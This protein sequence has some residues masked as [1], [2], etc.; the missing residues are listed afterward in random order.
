VLEQALFKMCEQCRDEGHGD[1]W[2]VF[3]RRVIQPFWHG[4]PEPTCEELV[5]ELG[6]DSPR[7]ASNALITAKRHFRRVLEE[8]V[9]QYLCDGED[10]ANELNQ[11][12]SIAGQS[13]SLEVDFTGVGRSRSGAS[14]NRAVSESQWTDSSSDPVLWRRL[15]NIDNI[16]TQPWSTEELSAIWRDQLALP[17]EPE[18]ASKLPGGST[19]WQMRQR[20]EVS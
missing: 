19:M 4:L 10:V 6:L 13:G 3:D 7:Q 11:L 20:L 12:A 18:G 1:R 15:L 9:A 5:R 8:T 14:G 16:P 2:R 17:A